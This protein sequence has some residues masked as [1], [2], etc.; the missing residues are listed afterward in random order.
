MDPE[1][2]EVVALQCGDTAGGFLVISCRFA[3]TSDNNKAAFTA[4]RLPLNE[5]FEILEKFR[6][7][8]L[9]Y[10]QRP[11]NRR[12]ISTVSNPLSPQPITKTLKP[13]SIRISM[14]LAFAG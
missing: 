3:A 12:P 10:N 2:I 5:S 9:G 1:P 4:A 6:V 8:S 14:S 7:D 13:C 11:A